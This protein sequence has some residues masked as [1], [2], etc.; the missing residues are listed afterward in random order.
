MQ[1]LRNLQLGDSETEAKKEAE[2]DYKLNTLGEKIVVKKPDTLFEVHTF[3]IDIDIG[4][5]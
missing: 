5:Q 1:D 4:L 3:N 2:R